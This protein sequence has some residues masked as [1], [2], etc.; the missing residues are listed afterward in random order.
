MKPWIVE[1]RAPMTGHWPAGALEALRDHPAWPGHAGPWLDAGGPLDAPEFV[2]LGGMR[3]RMSI[4]LPSRPI[5]DAC[6]T[7]PGAWC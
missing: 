3:C 6:A 4:S 2:P 1:T 7:R 5:V